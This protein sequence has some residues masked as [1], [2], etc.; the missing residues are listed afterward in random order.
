MTGQQLVTAMLMAT[1][2]MYSGAAIGYLMNG[3]GGMAVA[4]CGY[5]VANIGLIAEAWRV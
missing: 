3:Q 5:V 4:F 1:S 2:L